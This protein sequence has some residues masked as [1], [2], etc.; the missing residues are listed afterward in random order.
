MSSK[1]DPKII[2]EFR[3]KINDNNFFVMHYFCDFLIK[4][5]K[6]RKDL[7]SKIC[8]CMDWITVATTG[9]NKPIFNTKDMNLASLQFAHFIVTI[10][11]IVEGTVNLWRVFESEINKPYPLRGDKSIFNVEVFG[12]KVSD[13]EYFKQLRSWFGIHSVNGNQV[14]LPGYEERVRFFSSW[15]SSLD[16]KEFGLSLYSNNRE[17]EKQ[18]GGY[19]KVNVFDL[20]EYANIRYL[21]LI[22]LMYEVDKLYATTKKN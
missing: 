19:K 6:T 17:A 9:I 15:S 20:I 4:D 12:K 1:L 10:D 5:Q 13:D 18:Y 3:N 22:D 21:T 14:K 7:W 2:L 16:G 11:I 8:S